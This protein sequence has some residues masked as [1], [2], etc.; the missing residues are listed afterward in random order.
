M[1]DNEYAER[2]IEDH[3]AKCRMERATCPSSP[4]ITRTFQV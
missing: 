4:E 2:V 3:P 1:K